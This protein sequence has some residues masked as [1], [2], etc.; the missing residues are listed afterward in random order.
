M[1]DV[2]IGSTDYINN[3]H[4]E[5]DKAVGYFEDKSLPLENETMFRVH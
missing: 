5:E 2:A 1:K 4:D 3:D